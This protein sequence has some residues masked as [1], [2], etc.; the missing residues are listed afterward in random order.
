MIIHITASI[1]I[2]FLLFTFFVYLIIHKPKSNIKE[3]VF[4]EEELS[5]FIDYVREHNIIQSEEKKYVVDFTH[6]KSKLL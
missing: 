4:T 5:T 3:Y 2:L 6:D 1:I